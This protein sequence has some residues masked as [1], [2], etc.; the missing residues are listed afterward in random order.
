MNRRNDWQY[1]ATRTVLLFAFASSLGN[2]TNAHAAGGDG[3]GRGKEIYDFYCYQCHA[4]SGNANTVAAAYLTPKPRDFSRTDPRLLPREQMLKAVRDGK[5]GTAMVSFARVLGNDEMAA[6][7]D[8]IR[9]N[10]MGLQRPELAYHT[11]ANGWENHQRYEPAFAFA[12]GKV[13]I[14]TAWEDLSPKQR[15]GKQLFLSACI[16]CHE[17][18]RAGKEP[19][20]FEPR[21]VSYPRSTDTCVDCHA[22]RPPQLLPLSAAQPHALV[23]G[24]SPNHFPEQFVASPYLS[25]VQPTPASKLSENATRG[26]ELFLENCAFCHA[27]D[28]SSRNWIGSFLQPRPRDLQQGAISVTRSA[29]QLAE[30]IRHGIAGTSMPA[31]RTVLEES[32]IADLVAFLLHGQGASSGGDAT[33]G[34]TPSLAADPPLQ[35]TRRSHQRVE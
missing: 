12:L 6:V 35:W 4:Y 23:D 20:T 10:L 34:A 19:L 2:A 22:A 24:N 5:P 17:P 11:P 25:H 33:K 32:E 26:K 21:A 9:S 29:T 15:T 27:A 28:G 7:I 1:H 18:R 3:L 8:Y 30:I 13:P 14:D 31:W 16:T